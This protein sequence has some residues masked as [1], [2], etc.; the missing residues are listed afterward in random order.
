MGGGVAGN[1]YQGT[2]VFIRAPCGIGPSDGG[3]NEE[4]GGSRGLPYSA[5]PLSYFPSY[6]PS[7]LLFHWIFHCLFHGFFHWIFSLLIGCCPFSAASG[8]ETNPWLPVSITVVV[9]VK[10]IHEWIR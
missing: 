4:Y 1:G 8:L 7:Y 2:D 6:F 9:I 5:F 10:W 3:G